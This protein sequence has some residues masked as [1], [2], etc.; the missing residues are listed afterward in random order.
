MIKRPKEY[1][2]SSGSQFRYHRKVV[3]AG[4][5]SFE[6]NRGKEWCV[7]LEW[8]WSERGGVSDVVEDYLAC[9]WYVVGRVGV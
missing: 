5:K 4:R 1:E 3:S 2:M 9:G 8:G 7:R 6:E